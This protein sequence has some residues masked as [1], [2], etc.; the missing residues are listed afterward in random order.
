MNIIRKKRSDLVVRFHAGYVVNEV[1]GCWEWQ[2][3]IQ[4]NGYGHIKEGGKA[5]LVHRVS[6]AL[7]KGPIPEGAYVLH[8]CDNRCC[9]SPLHLFVGTALDN[10]IDM[11]SKMRHAHGERVN[12]AKLTEKEVL[13]IYA[14]SDSGVGSRRIGAKYGVSTTMAWNIK[15]GRAWSHLFKARYGIHNSV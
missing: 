6:F 15:T 9:V 8:Q 1:T 3:N 12:T 5:K 14:M 7:H 4:A 11:Q 2:K 10:R 13:E